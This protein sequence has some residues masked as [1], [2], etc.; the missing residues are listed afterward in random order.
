[1]QGET[2]LHVINGAIDKPLRD[3]KLLEQAICAL[4]DS[5]REDLLISRCVRVHWDPYH[6][7]RVKQAYKRKFKIDLG[8]RMRD[9]VVD[10]VFEDFLVKMIRD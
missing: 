4:I 8:K 1:M 10:G 5:G 7:E 3:A 6:L 2:L 9:A